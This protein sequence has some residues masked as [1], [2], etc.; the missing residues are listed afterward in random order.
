M[1]PLLRGFG[2]VICFILYSMLINAVTAALHLPVPG[3]IVGIVLLFALLHFKV[4]KLEW[5][6]LGSKWLLAE[7]LL[8]FIPPVVGIV[9]Y[10]DLM[11]ENGLR[12]T[13]VIVFSILCV[14]VITGL[15]AEK[16]SAHEGK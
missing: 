14:M 1:K 13:L 9:E 3:S 10:K 7:M 6:D 15:I 8:F 2:Q 12:I 4:I 11:L 5:V 16:L